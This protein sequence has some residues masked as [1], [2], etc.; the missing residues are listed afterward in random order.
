VAAAARRGRPGPGRGMSQFGAYDA[1]LT[2]DPGCWV[3]PIE[4]Y[5]IPHLDPRSPEYDLEFADRVAWE[6]PGPDW[7][8]PELE[9]GG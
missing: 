4:V 5:W 8:G 7:N 1:G 6:E 9:T 3:Q 2:G